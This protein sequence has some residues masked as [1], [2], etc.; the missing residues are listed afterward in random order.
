MRMA[1]MT[2]VVM[3]GREMK[4]AAGFISRPLRPV[5][6]RPSRPGP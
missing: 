1:A 5:R 2:R 6:Q 3:T 4:T